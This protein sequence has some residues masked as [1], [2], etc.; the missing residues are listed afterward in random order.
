MAVVARSAT[1]I[2]HTAAVAVVASPGLAANLPDGDSFPNGG[3]TVLVM[4]NTGA[5]AYYVDVFQSAGQDGLPAQARRFTI[6]ATTIH[7]V[8]LGPPSVYGATTL[9]KAENVAV[10]L[11]AKAL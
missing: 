5:S 7:E 10:K 4:N 8:K 2:G 9:V 11:S 1:T 6:P 3:S